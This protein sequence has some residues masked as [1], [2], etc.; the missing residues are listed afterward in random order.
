MSETH[1]SSA[2]VV[3]SGAPGCSVVE[4]LRDRLDKEPSEVGTKLLKR[5]TDV[6]ESLNFFGLTEEDPPEV[7]AA[8]RRKRLSIKIAKRAAEPTAEASP[9]AEVM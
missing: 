5:L 4:R 7:K 1:G 6:S 2:R 3:S 8:N 9:D